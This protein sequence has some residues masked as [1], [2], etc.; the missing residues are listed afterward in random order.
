[1]DFPRSI[2]RDDVPVDHEKG[3]VV[4][5][6][7]EEAGVSLQDVLRGLV[8]ERDDAGDVVEGVLLGDVPTRPPD[9]EAELG[10]GGDPGAL[11][12]ELDHAA[13]GR[14]GVFALDEEDGCVWIALTD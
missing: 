1:P 3:R 9:D 11:P 12:G 14:Q 8:E 7:D 6:P 5:A 4:L 13:R 10:L 2:D